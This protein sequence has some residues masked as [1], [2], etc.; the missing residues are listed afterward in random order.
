MRALTWLKKRWRRATK[1]VLLAVVASAIA[2]LVNHFGEEILSDEGDPAS[3]IH[4]VAESSL[5]NPPHH[6]TAAGEYVCLVNEA[7]EE[8]SLTSWKLYDSAGRINEFGQ[9]SLEPGGSVRVHPG[10]RPRRNTS[11]DVYGDSD[12][13]RWTNSGDTI[14]L[15]NAADERVE[16]QSYPSRQDG[17]IG[18]NCGP[19]RRRDWDCT[20]FLSHAQAQA[21]F[22]T[23]RPA[24]DPFEL[25]ADGDGLACE[26]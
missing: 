26:A 1:W 18:D 9:F 7:E 14:F 13:P 6:D 11:L 5:V 4:V 8:V 20:G 12:I 25:D 23:H 19:Q 21:F 16:T 24:R 22:L 2:L 17:D 3:G 10:G 15:R